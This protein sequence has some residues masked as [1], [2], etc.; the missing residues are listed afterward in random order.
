MIDESVNDPS[1]KSKSKSV[2]K[3]NNEPNKL[4]FKYST[5]S[6]KKIAKDVGSHRLSKNA[7]VKLQT[8][9]NDLINKVHARPSLI[10]FIG[11]LAK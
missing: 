9:I 3:K 10:N 4:P 7:I 8:N 6:I 11:K 5:A 2:R 1:K